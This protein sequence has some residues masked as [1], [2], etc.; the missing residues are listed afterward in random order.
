MSFGDSKYTTRWE[1]T[2]RQF[3]KLLALISGV[4]SIDLFGPS[5]KMA[6]GKEGD[7]TLEEMRKKAIQVF[8]KPKRFH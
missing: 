8:N 1:A 3:L 6:F 4:S 2:R 7:M 5:K